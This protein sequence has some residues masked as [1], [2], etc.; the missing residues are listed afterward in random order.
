MLVISAIPAVISQE[1]GSLA[2]FFISIIIM[3]VGTGGFKSNISPLVAEQT[4]H[5]SLKVKTLKDGSKVLLDPA[6]TSSKIFMYF[7][8][9]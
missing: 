6:L 1:K 7:Y 4:T 5:T 2:L 9:M 8:L 3:G